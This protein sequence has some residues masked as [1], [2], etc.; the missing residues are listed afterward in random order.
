MEQ[1][2]EW[3]GSPSEEDPANFWEDDD[4][5]EYVDA[6]TGERMTREQALVLIAAERA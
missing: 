3:S 5:G 4:T 1:Q 6:R 2:A